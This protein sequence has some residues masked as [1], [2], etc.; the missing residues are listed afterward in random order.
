MGHYLPHHVHWTRH[1][2]RHPLS[3]RLYLQHGVQPCARSHPQLPL[4]HLLFTFFSLPSPPLSIPTQGLSSNLREQSVHFRPAHNGSHRAGGIR[5]PSVDVYHRCAR[6]VAFIDRTDHNVLVRFPSGGRVGR[7][8]ETTKG[9]GAMIS[10]TSVASLVRW[11][12]HRFCI[13]AGFCSYDPPPIEYIITPSTPVRLGEHVF[14]N[15]LYQIL[16]RNLSARFP[17]TREQVFLLTSCL[18]TDLES[19]SYRSRLLCLGLIGRAVGESAVCVTR[20]Y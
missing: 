13:R 3:F 1:L 10:G 8:V 15:Y 16:H 7:R 14:V 5:L 11:S 9:L 18:D 19:L 12:H 17:Q 4:G 2:P 6:V 20:G